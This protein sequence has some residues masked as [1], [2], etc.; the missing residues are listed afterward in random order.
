M[1]LANFL[2]IILYAC[3][4]LGLAGNIYW[5]FDLFSHFQY[6]YLFFFVASLVFF[7]RKKRYVYAFSAAIIVIIILFKILPPTTPPILKTNITRTSLSLL[8]INVNMEN[9]NH[10]IVNKVIK[11]LSPDILL[12]I[13]INKAWHNNIMLAHKQYRHNIIELR[14]DYFGIGLYSKTMLSETRVNYLGGIKIP[15]IYAKL[16]KKDK[17]ISIYGVHLDWPVTKSGSDHQNSQIIDLANLVNREKSPSIVIG[18]FNLTP[19]SIRYRRFVQNTNIN[20][21]NDNKIFS[22]TWPRELS[23]LSIPI[24]HCFSTNEVNVINLS[25]LSE[26][27]GSDH[28]PIY[29]EIEY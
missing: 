11:R 19:W 1:P 20:N 8:S 10:E 3:F 21:C 25:I 14:D 29:V 28:F 5:F 16:T 23:F 26:D 27:I 6:H 15:A 17:T 18:D 12:L 24:D 22:G 13:E 4:L 2:Y 7:L 9:T